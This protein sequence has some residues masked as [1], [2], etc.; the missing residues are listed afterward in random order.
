MT[1]Y[2]PIGAIC[3]VGIW[4]SQNG[5]YNP[6]VPEFA[7]WLEKH[8]IQWQADREKRGS[9]RQFSDWLGIDHRLISRWMNGE[10]K[11]GPDHLDTLAYKF[12]DLSCYELLGYP[13]PD[14]LLLRI[15]MEWDSLPEET[16]AAVGRVL[17]KAEHE[18]QWEEAHKR[19]PARK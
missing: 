10:R 7:S 4:K 8:Y 14:K 15:K 18:P 11:P 1:T 2:Y 13:T 17:E 12:N 9:I 5:P 16:R 19:A 3:Q 6:L